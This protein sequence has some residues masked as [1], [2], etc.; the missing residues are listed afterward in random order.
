MDALNYKLTILQAS[1]GYG[2]STALAALA[3]ETGSAIWYQVTEED[4]DPLVFLLHLCH[5]THRVLPHLQGLPVNYLEEWEGEQ[6]PLPSAG[7][8]DQ[9]IN[10]LSEQ[11]DLPALLILDDLHT[12]DAA[13]EIGLILDRLAGLAPFNLHI[14]L[15]SR[16]PVRLPNLSRWR[17]QGKV[18]TLD[19]SV[20]AF[21]GAEITALFSQHYGVELTQDEVNTLLAN[22]EGWAIALQLIWQSLRSGSFGSL[23]ESLTTQA[24]SLEGLFDIL[25]REVFGGQPP[26]V[27][28]FLL[29][30]ATLREMTAEACDALR[31]PGENEVP[32][33]NGNSPGRLPHPD[34]AAMLAYLRR[35]ELFVV[36]HGDGSLRY[37]HIFHTFLRQQASTN[38]RKIW[39]ARAADFFQGQGDFDATVYHL[40]LAEDQEAAAELLDTFGSQL[41]TVG[42][43]DSLTQYLGSILPA[44]LYQ[45]PALLSYLGDLARLHSRFQEAL[46]WYQQ[47]EE[48]WRMRGQMDGAARALRGQ[49]RIYLDTV[50]PSRA[51][52]LLQKS[53]RLHDGMESRESQA[54]LYE[55]LA[56][57]RLN[58]G[59]ADEAERLRQ[60][61]EALRSE[62]PSDSQLL[63]RVLLRTGRLDEAR[64]RLEARAEAERH[65]PVQTPRAH[66]E[67]LLLLSLIYAFQ[68]KAEE[69][70]QTALEGTR[71]GVDL[72]SPYI[73]AV[74]YMRQGHA[75]MLRPRG[76]RS[77]D[78]R[79][80][81]LDSIQLS[82]MLAVPR[83]MVESYWGL[84]REAGYRGDLAQA[85]QYAQEGIEI[86]NQAG[87]EWIASLTRLAVG[88]SL[89]LSSRYE[90]AKEWLERASLGFQECSD[91][92]GRTASRMWICLGWF[93]QGT[94]IALEQIFPDLLRTCQELGYDFLLTQ[95]TLLGPPDERV[96]IPLLIYARD[97]G[98]ESNY[99][100]HLLASL[101]L[102][103][104]I[105]H[106]GY[107][108]RVVTLGNFQTWLGIQPVP[109]NG[110]RRE[111]ARQLFQ[112][113]LTYRDAPLDRDQIIEYLWPGQDPATAGRNF[114]VALN[115]LYQVLEPERQPG[116]DSTYI[117]REGSIYSLRP[118]A[119]IWLDTVEFTRRIQQGEAVLE[120]RP[121]EGMTIIQSALDLYQG[122]YLPEAR[123]ETW[124]AAEREHLAV[125]FLRAAD[126]LSDLYLQKGEPQKSAELCQRILICDN[127]W[128]RAYRHLMV[129]Y[130]QMGDHG[131]LARTYQRC[132]QTLRQEL[133][134]SP[135]PETEALYRELTSNQ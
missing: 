49:A 125:L 76:I 50:N 16:A 87:D 18:L 88:A 56:E 14:L 111:K 28:Q 43:L 113:L 131:Q 39:H 134:V 51:E 94:L 129:A 102:A 15:A 110:W 8:I 116:S 82:R 27:Q 10:V 115:T 92:F 52:E 46:G 84:C 71:R 77:T 112:L 127:C 126:R 22:T 6:G 135:A 41:L 124:T 114:K 80:Q 98:W 106:P 25:A 86:A 103:G 104:I 42:R 67:T 63:F 58:A 99:A 55:L 100:A 19:Q 20:L 59:R 101:D 13:S 90:A 36:E 73:T 21:N 107:Q 37:H 30:S 2:K 120:N 70:Y 97:H 69:A 117:L 40:L 85:L 26:D 105:S 74:G 7:V 45:H 78:A 35:Q 91:P 12:L 66:R 17:A 81:F 31:Y 24:G 65:N 44:I 93:R 62:G 23:E 128:E 34:S 119:D 133:D 123:Y 83:L 38:Q 54:R 122:E 29:V 108:L 5:A 4:G 64:Q 48:V 72:H 3:E 61:A 57:N 95:P 118:G 60:Q 121:E 109:S 33:E 89:T 68:G 79:Q 130:D 132:V 32:A 96:I 75:L 53:I 11:L 47:A 9:F 1:A